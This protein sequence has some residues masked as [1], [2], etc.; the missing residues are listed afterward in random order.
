MSWTHLILLLV[1]AFAV[2]VPLGQWRSRQR[3]LSP[4]WL[5]GI[6]AGIP[7]IVLMRLIWDLS[8]YVI[9]AEVAAIVGGQ[10]LGARWRQLRRTT[11]VSAVSREPIAE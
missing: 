11:G 1:V 4:R 10:I 5:L 7:L 9:P 8:P 2:N 3:K 6:H